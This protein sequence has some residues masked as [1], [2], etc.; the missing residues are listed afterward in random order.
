LAWAIEGL[1]A[2]HRLIPEGGHLKKAEKIAMEISRWQQPSGCWNFRYME[3]K[4]KVGISEKG[5][6][7]W[8]YIF[9]KLY[10][11][12]GKENY[13]QTARDALIWCLNKSL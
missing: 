13:L 12:T 10:K 11:I 1:L 9:Y 5:T 4:E 6:A 8:S 2:A 3:S 7:I